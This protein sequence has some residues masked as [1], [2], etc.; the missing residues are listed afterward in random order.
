LENR[1]NN[2]FPAIVLIEGRLANKIRPKTIGH[3]CV[4]TLI[5]DHN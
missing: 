4:K 5:N 3:S 2:H 1:I